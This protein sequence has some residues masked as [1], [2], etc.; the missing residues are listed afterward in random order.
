[1]D[2]DNGNVCLHEKQQKNN[3]LQHTHK[4]P[5]NSAVHL[6]VSLLVLQGSKSS[7]QKSFLESL[8]RHEGSNERIYYCN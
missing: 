6:F 1:M 7:D 2:M 5:R 3:L 4:S 8:S